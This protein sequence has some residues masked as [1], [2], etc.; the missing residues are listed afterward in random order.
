ML[1][2][3]LLNITSLPVTKTAIKDS[4]LGS[5]I[6]AIGKHEIC[7]D[8]HNEHAIKEKI[9][10]LKD[11]WNSY[12]KARKAEKESFKID[13]S[14]DTSKRQAPDAVAPNSPAKRRKIDSEAKV[15]MDKK[16]DTEPRK[17]SLFKTLLNARIGDSSKMNSKSKENMASIVPSRLVSNTIKGNS[18]NTI[19]S[20][21]DNMK[22][23]RYFIVFIFTVGNSFCRLTLLVYDI[24][25]CKVKKKWL[26]S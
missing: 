11:S 24:C 23:G 1:L 13:A 17:A 12:V 19:V 6:G 25:R 21:R 10:Q 14:S 7:K 18:S 9:N 22:E 5:T 20:K 2:H 4:G 16:M 3:L 8:T 26:T 15:S